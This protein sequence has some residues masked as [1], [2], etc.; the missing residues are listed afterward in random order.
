MTVFMISVRKSIQR[1][2]ERMPLRLKADEVV[3]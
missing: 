3:M 2:D 1:V